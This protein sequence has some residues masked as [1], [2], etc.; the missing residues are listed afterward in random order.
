VTS[1]VERSLVLEVGTLRDAMAA[2]DAGEGQIALAVDVTGRLVG[3]VTDGDV[4]RAILR[5][6]DPDDPLA[7][8]LTRSFV[9]VGPADG[10]AEVLDLIRARWIS[11]VP[12]IDERGKPIGLHLLQQFFRPKNRPN[13]AVIMAGGEGRRLRPLTDSLPK[14]MLRVAG[15]PILER[16]ILHLVGHG[17]ER[18]FL[19]VNY[20]GEMIEEHFGDGST[21]GAKIDYLREKAP[22]GTAGALGLLPEPPTRAILVMN[23]D[24]VTQAD[25]GGL[26]DFHEGHGFP[27]TV[28]VRRYLH[29][30]PFGC[31]TRDGDRVVSLEEKPTVVRDVSAGIYA[32]DPALVRRVQRDRPLTMPELIGGALDRGEA[33]GAFELE[34][35][36]IDIGQPEQLDQARRGG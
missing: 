18:I 25:L 29:E 15:R 30:V 19:A 32:L 4:R 36:W 3:V 26:L 20:L 10:R 6:S 23:G 35:D 21:L 33:V 28:G 8:H 13:W 11:A 14:P 31:V 34:D 1:A 2:L 27:A 7:P 16:I 5:G 12:V 24:L 9:A 17:V 22:L